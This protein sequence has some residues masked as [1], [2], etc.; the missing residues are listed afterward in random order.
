MSCYG[1][2][3]CQGGLSSEGTITDGPAI[4]S[5]N[6]ECRWLV[7]ADGGAISLVFSQLD[8]EYNYDFVTV[9]SCSEYTCSTK[10]LEQILTGVMPSSGIQITVQNYLLVLFKTDSSL[11]YNGFTA[12]YY[13]T[14]G[15]T[16]CP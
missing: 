10:K 7:E 13:A 5:N 8:V 11:V 2:C 9:Y 14:T 3:L 1:G 4:Y 15:C 12:Q 16:I 6:E